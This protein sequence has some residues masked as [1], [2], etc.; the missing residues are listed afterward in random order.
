MCIGYPVL[1]ENLVLVG[2]WPPCG[3]DPVESLETN[4]NIITLLTPNN[5]ISIHSAGTIFL[6]VLMTVG[7]WML[8]S[9][10][11]WRLQFSINVDRTVPLMIHRSTSLVFP[12]AC[13]C[14]YRTN[15]QRWNNSLSAD[16]AIVMVRVVI[17]EK[18][19]LC[20]IMRG[21]WQKMC[22]K[23]VRVHPT[24]CISRLNARVDLACH[25][26]LEWILHN[27]LPT[28]PV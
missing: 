14:V 25:T 28:F 19:S 6:S 12:S 10:W 24:S 22:M 27:H 11:L 7:S 20:R 3:K 4:A 2:L 26:R 9:H 21:K 15:F 17:C 8:W 13:S 16:I 5:R 1:S 23:F 18:Q